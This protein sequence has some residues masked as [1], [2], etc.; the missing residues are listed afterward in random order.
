MTPKI[1]FVTT[2][3]NDYLDTLKYFLLDKNH[4]DSWR[5]TIFLVYPDLKE[6]LEK[7]DNKEKD[8]ENFFRQKEKKF[9]KFFKKIRDDFQKSWDKINDEVMIALEDI[10]E[11]KWPKKFK[12]FGARITLNPI[13]PR[14]LDNN[15]FDVYFGFADMTMKSIVLHEVSH[16]IFFEKFKEIYPK[17]N[18]KEFESPYLIWKLSEIMP[19]IILNDKRIQKVFHHEASDFVYDCFKKEI[20]NKRLLD[21]FRKFYKDRKSFRDFV[22][23]SY[24]FVKKHESE[25]NKIV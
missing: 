17:T 18:K 14:Y 12:K 11:I 25:I 15:A 24:D 9:N 21:Y 4:G 10:N 5:E 1:E 16:F 8:I 19:A 3:L 23:K 22:E 7:S 2:E 13:C 20:D 6:K